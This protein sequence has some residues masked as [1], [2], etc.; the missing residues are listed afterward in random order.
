MTILIVQCAWCNKPLG[1][2]DGK[3]VSG[4]SHGICKSCVKKYFKK[5]LLN[6]RG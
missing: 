1:Q 3:G 2:K 5:E 4:I 6:V